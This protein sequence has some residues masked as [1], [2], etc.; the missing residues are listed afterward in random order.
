MS[1]RKN[2]QKQRA[3][4]YL[5][6]E[7]QVLAQPDPVQEAALHTLPAREL[8]ESACCSCHDNAGKTTSRGMIV[9]QRAISAGYGQMHAVLRH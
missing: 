9:C 8:R 1:S 5:G 7:I 6:L 2:T 3:Y 4:R